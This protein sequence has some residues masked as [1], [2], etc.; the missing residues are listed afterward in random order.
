MEI[1][2]IISAIRGNQIRIS[3]YADDEAV[4]DDLTYEEIYF[5]F[6]MAK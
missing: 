3:N 1:E 2:H 4:D 6:S 5:L